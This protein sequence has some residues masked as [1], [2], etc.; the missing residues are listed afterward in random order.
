MSY[1]RKSIEVSWISQSETWHC[2]EN[3]EIASPIAWAI[4]F[5]EFLV[6]RGNTDKESKKVAEFICDEK[7]LTTSQIRKF[8]GV[9]KKI[10]AEGYDKN[11][12]KL[13]MLEPQ[14]AYAVGKDKKYDS[15]KRE[16]INQTKIVYLYEEIS[17]ALRTVKSA[18]H[19]QN[20]VNLLEAIVAYHKAK[21][22]E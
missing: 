9:I 18:E 12:I 14:L 13:A 16:N 22:G 21:G 8:F 2:K 4:S 15:T 5:A 1:K 10:Q 20:F 11:K 7:P 17:K 6:V 19:F 3:E